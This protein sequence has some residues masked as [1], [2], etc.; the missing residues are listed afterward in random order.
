MMKKTSM[1]R[2]KIE[3][4]RI[5][6]EDSRQVTFSKRRSGLF[7]K[8]SELCT[9]C[10]AESALIVFS[11][12][13]KAFSFGHP[14]VDSILD[15]FFTQDIPPEDSDGVSS[16]LPEGHRGG[17]IY[18]LNRQYTE[19]FNKLEAEKKRA[20]MLKQISKPNQIQSWWEAPI[21]NLSLHELEQLKL[22][23]K[24]LKHSVAKRGNE[25]LMDSSSQSPFLA[26]NSLSMVDPFVHGHKPNERNTPTFPH[27]HGYSL[28]NWNSSS[29]V[30]FGLGLPTVPHRLGLPSTINTSNSVSHSSGLIGD[31]VSF[32]PHNFGFG[33][34]LF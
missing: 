31:N 9:L 22:I 33:H 30:A 3:I 10:G 23:M 32:I 12:A 27:G 24:E 19:A 25:L 20:Q 7:K 6:R 2:Q 8:A 34:R 4:K 29:S 5:D 15:R 18:E 16:S 14:S 11:P 21:E 17:I 1:G 28:P 26:F 13:G